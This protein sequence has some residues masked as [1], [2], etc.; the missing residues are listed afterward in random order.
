M[1]VGSQVLI[2]GGSHEGLSGE[3]IAMKKQS[4]LA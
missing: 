4:G 1:M 3:I 2:I